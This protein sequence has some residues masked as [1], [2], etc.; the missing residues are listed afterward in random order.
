ML[1]VT[2]ETPSGVGFGRKPPLFMKAGDTIEVTARGVGTLRNPVA[3]A[4]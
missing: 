2:D 4:V 3:A 1:I